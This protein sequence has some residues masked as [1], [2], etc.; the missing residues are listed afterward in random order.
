MING[1]NNMQL[2]RTSQIIDGLTDTLLIALTG[3]IIWLGFELHQEKKRDPLS[4]LEAAMPYEDLNKDGV[5]DLVIQQSDGH[6]VP[7]YGTMRNGIFAK[8]L[9]G[10]EMQAMNPKDKTD[11]EGI[12]RQLNE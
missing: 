5:S 10:S 2:S 7:M 6:L 3:G 11:Y 9:S 4:P 12:E 8:Y 1:G